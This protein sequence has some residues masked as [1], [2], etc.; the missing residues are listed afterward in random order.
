M[1]FRGYGLGPC[2]R[3]WLVAV[4]M[5]M[6]LQKGSIGLAKGEGGG[7]ERGEERTEERERVTGYRGDECYPEEYEP[8][9]VDGPAAV[10]HWWMAKLPREA[11]E[12][13]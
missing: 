5:V 6:V 10:I 4:Y 2:S 1:P 11:R 3:S 13:V 8:C 12:H 7:E 9:D